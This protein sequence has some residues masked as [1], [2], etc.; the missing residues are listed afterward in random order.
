MIQELM[1]NENI[2]RDLEKEQRTGDYDEK[3]WNT[4]RDGIF[5]RRTLSYNKMFKRLALEMFGENKE[6]LQERHEHK[7]GDKIK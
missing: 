3:D 4:E 2:K 7:S 5:I 1:E 6:I